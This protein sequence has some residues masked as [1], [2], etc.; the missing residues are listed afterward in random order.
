MLDRLKRPSTPD[1]E[2]DIVI[3]G[4]GPA[5]ITAARKLK[6]KG[7]DVWI[8]GSVY[9]SQIAKAGGLKDVSSIPENTIGLD[10]VEKMIEEAKNDG[11]QHKTSLCTEIIFEKPFIVKTKYQNFISPKILIATGAKQV[12]LGFKGESDFLHKGI[13]DCA[14]C[15]WG[16]F[17]GKKIAVLGDHEYTRRAAVFMKDHVPEVHLLWYQVDE[18]IQEEGIT[19]Y[20]N[21]DN[22]VAL[23]DETLM[24]L[25]FTSAQKEFEIEVEGLF[26]EGNPKPAT[27]IFENTPI[28]L[29]D[30]YVV[31][32]NNN[33]TTVDGIWAVGD[34]TGKTSNYDEAVSDAEKIASQIMD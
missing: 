14:V 7:L 24:G 26:V 4:A 10:H 6:E 33:L 23:G 3:I 20:S 32:D 5:G 16:L 34:V 28:K 27:K 1:I 29:D 25:K 13:S 12:P 18:N 22:L 15:D 9:E 19:F 31:T 2:T 21:V 11:V 17:R 8:L 30:G